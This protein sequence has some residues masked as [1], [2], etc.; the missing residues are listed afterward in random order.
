MKLQFTPSMRDED[1]NLGLST[2][3]AIGEV[4]EDTFNGRS[5]IILD[6][7]LDV[8]S[9]S[10]RSRSEVRAT[11]TWMNVERLSL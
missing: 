3:A 9:D 1:L 7:M 5:E 2:K 6:I 8:H 11:K 4:I 10:A